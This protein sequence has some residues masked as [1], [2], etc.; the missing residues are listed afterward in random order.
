MVLDPAHESLTRDKPT[1]HFCGTKF[2]PGYYYTCHVCDAAYCYIHM[3]KHVRA[4][5]PPSTQPE[6]PAW[7][8]VPGTRA[9]IPTSNPEEVERIRSYARASPAKAKDLIL[10]P[11]EHVKVP[12]TT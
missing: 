12:F 3:N 8:F 10:P 6:V 11:S 1:C 4:H 9:E 2:D 7:E 5:R